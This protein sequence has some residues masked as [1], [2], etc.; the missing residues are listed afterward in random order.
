MKR[1]NAK[2][3]STN[4][5]SELKPEVEELQKVVGIALATFGQR[6]ARSFVPGSA[7]ALQ[8]GAGDA[9]PARSISGNGY[10]SGQRTIH[11]HY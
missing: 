7:L 9:G 11:L 3:T 1:G 8:L 5:Y 6:P 10:G 2:L 4:L